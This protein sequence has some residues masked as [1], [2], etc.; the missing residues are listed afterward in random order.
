MPKAFLSLILLFVFGCTETKPS[1]VHAGY[2]LGTSYAI[3]YTGIG[4]SFDEVQNGIDSLFTVINKSMSTYIPNSDISK[5]NSGDSL[6][7]V[8]AHFI[9]VYEKATEVWKA[10]DGYFDPTVG[11]WVNAYGFGPKKPIKTLT[12]EKK[13]Y[14]SK[15]TGWHTIELTVDS[16]IKK[17]HLETY[18]DFNA[19]AKGY[20]VDV[21]AEYLSKLGSS[22]YLVEIGGEIVAFGNSPKTNL[23]WSIAIDDPKQQNERKMIQRLSLNN[24]AIATSGNY[25][26]FRVDVETG[27]RYVHS[28][29]PLTGIP[30]KSNVLSASV[31]AA[32]CMTADAY[33]TA[34]MVLPLETSM[35]LIKKLTDVEAYWITASNDSIQEYFSDGWKK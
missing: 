15:I 13:A 8:D 7:Q 14:L 2:A 21:L 18:L 28:I 27:E 29:N 4:M 22:N 16:T 23:P 20:A 24:E 1:Q 30:V 34:L 12:Q 35:E 9:K 25:R 3:Q 6:L 17:S 26:K 19:L 11:A 10:T 31:R 5:I 33:A 32:D